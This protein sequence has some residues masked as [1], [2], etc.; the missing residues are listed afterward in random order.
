MNYLFDTFIDKA[1]TEL[2][3]QNII[4]TIFTEYPIYVC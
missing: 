1:H 4:T 3:R 2:D